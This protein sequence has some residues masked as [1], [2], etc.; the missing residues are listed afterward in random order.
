V[1]KT[2][3]ALILY[4]TAEK[5]EAVESLLTRLDVMPPQ[6]LIEATVAEVT[7]VDDLRYGLEWF[8][9]NIDGSQSSILS[10]IDGLNLGS[11][12]INLSTV[13]DSEKFR[14]LVNAL[15]EEELVQ[16]LSSPRI[17]VR[18]GKSATINVGSQVPV[19]TSETASV[20]SAG[21][22][23]TGVLR[24]YQYR[25][26]GVILKLTPTVHA[27]DVVT[28]EISQE[29]SEVGAS[30]TQNP[31]ILNRTL[32]TDVVANAGQTLVIGGLIKEN[33]SS[34]DSKVPFFGDLPIIGHLF[35]TTSQGR[36][37]TELVVMITPHILRASHE[38][39]ALRDAFFEKFNNL[40]WDSVK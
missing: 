38:A 21:A 12:G 10:T 1:D 19:V 25:D 32:D 23:G 7:L 29:V 34:R 31:T 27:R 5:Y 22:E 37:R 20:E 3:N 36:E 39:D 17:T 33:N 15:A 40:S 4:A 14:L 30:G 11:A 28:L 2:R 6:V 26:T 16:V 24:T 9:K 18:D 13:T 8:L 35:K